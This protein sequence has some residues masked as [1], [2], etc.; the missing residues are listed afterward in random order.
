MSHDYVP[1]N[2]LSASV[3]VG[4]GTT[5]WNLADPAD[6]DSPERSFAFEVFFDNP[7]ARIPVVHL[8]LT[9]FDLEQHSSARL[10]LHAEQITEHGFVARITTWRSSQVYSASF[11][12]LA[13]GA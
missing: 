6:E 8:G 5:G 12:W 10:L 13:V 3:F 1:W 4:T 11:N 7:F 2:L 9:G